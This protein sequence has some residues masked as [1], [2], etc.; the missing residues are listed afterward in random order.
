MAKPKLKM[1]IE[2]LSKNRPPWAPLPRLWDMVY[3]ERL[4][5]DKRVNVDFV[6]LKDGNVVNP[7]G[8]AKDSQCV[9]FDVPMAIVNKLFRDA[10]RSYREYD[11]QREFNPEKDILGFN[12]PKDDASALIQE[13]TRLKHDVAD[14][15]RKF[16][17]LQQNLGKTLGKAVGKFPKPKDGL[18]V[19]KKDEL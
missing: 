15:Q 18:L 9:A 13:N 1:N 3:D 12:P 17:A 14:E 7:N 8:V 2:Y 16:V 6:M 11:P 10:P 5:R 4:G 19:P